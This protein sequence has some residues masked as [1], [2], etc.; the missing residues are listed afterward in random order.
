MHGREPI[1]QGDENSRYLCIF[2]I[3]ITAWYPVELC[4][5]VP[6]SNYPGSPVSR[7]SDSFP[8]I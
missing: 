5:A 4:Q 7:P 3:N 1:N 6:R 2:F 8:L